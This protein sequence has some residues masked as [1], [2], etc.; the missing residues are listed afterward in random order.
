MHCTK[1]QKEIPDQVRFCPYCGQPI[2]I[3][4]IHSPS[5]KGNLS[6]I[7][8]TT[9][10]TE[11]AT[12]AP[13]NTAPVK[14]DFQKI[15]SFKN[16]HSQGKINKKIICLLLA[17]VIAVISTIS[18]FVYQNN[19][20]T[21]LSYVHPDPAI[22]TDGKNIYV[23]TDITDS[24]KATLFIQTNFTMDDYVY[25]EGV[26]Y[27]MDGQVFSPLDISGTGKYLFY[28]NNV[29]TEDDGSMSG[30]LY[31]FDLD[32]L[33]SDMDAN[34]ENS[35]LIAENV[36]QMMAPPS[37]DN[38][39]FYVSNGSDLSC[40]TE[41]GGTINILSNIDKF[42]VRYNGASDEH[43]L[44]ILHDY[45]ETTESYIW[46][47]YDIKTESNELTLI[48]SNI[49]D[50]PK[51][52]GNQFIYTKGN[53]GEDGAYHSDLYIATL[54]KNGI[55][56]EKIDDNVMSVWD[57]GTSG[58]G[59][60][61]VYSKENEDPEDDSLFADS[62]Y[63]YDNGKILH[64]SDEDMQYSKS[65]GNLI[66]FQ[67][68]TDT[69][70]WYYQYKNNKEEAFDLTGIKEVS[71]NSAETYALIQ[72]CDADTQVNS[73]YLASI[74]DKGKLHV[75]RKLADDA[76]VTGSGYGLLLYEAGKNNTNLYRV[77]DD[78]KDKKY[79]SNI[80]ASDGINLHAPFSE[81]CGLVVSEQK[82]DKYQLT[83]FDKDKKQKT[84]ETQVDEFYVM[85]ST[86]LYTTDGK[87]YS[88]NLKTEKS[89][90]I[91]DQYSNYVYLYNGSVM[92]F[93]CN[94]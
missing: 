41:K 46:D 54:S 60:H 76:A 91:T 28:M 18:Y 39:V 55:T 8:P 37:S 89:K 16:N 59:L 56:K 15:F 51:K 47:S 45:N 68:D 1:C 80:T 25:P 24:Q 94:L 92:L 13:N 87:M 93:G 61:I 31:E 44:T 75:E 49:N 21:S 20:D 73:V 67:K 74:S 42:S 7:S 36:S 81:D 4:Q 27:N 65:D 85:G 3:T 88:F 78:G 63:I 29:V 48:D 12:A 62:T 72:T 50:T 22:Y 35:K 6:A 70:Q 69:D 82:G 2:S 84:L 38:S 34:S 9:Q 17:A 23:D 32:K 57:C 52:T 71:V 77:Y 26:V 11:E 86:I 58:K 43:M 10:K 5:L 83:Y 30:D 66:L 90:K 79:V 14:E 64:L 33:S 40:Y 53:K 19:Q